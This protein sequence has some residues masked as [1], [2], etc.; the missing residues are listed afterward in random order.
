M[1]AKYRAIDDAILAEVW[2]SCNRDEP[3]VNFNCVISVECGLHLS[4]SIF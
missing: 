4:E 1:Q 3:C 2:I